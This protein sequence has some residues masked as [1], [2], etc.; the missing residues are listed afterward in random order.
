MK[1]TILKRLA[2][3]LMAAAILASAAVGVSADDGYM[4]DYKYIAYDSY[5]LIYL[6]R[7]PLS[8]FPAANARSLTTTSYRVPYIIVSDLDSSDPTDIV[9]VLKPVVG[10]QTV[11]SYSV[12][13]FSNSNQLS[14]SVASGSFNSSSNV[15]SIYLSGSSSAYASGLAPFL[16]T[17]SSSYTPYSD[18]IS[19]YKVT[20]NYSPGRYYSSGY[21]V[22]GFG[23]TNFVLDSSLTLGDLV[24][25]GDADIIISGIT[26]A[27]DSMTNTLVSVGS[28]YIQFIPTQAASSLDSA[29]SSIE[30]SESALTGKSSSL[31]ESVA[32]EWTANKNTART[33]LA[34]IE[35]T[36][37]EIKNIYTTLTNA[38]PDEVL[39]LFAIIP[40]LLFIGFLIGRVK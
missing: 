15:S 19:S 34:T 2:V 32:S 11:E 25:G 40:L 1:I 10:T 18:L 6:S 33:F 4:A 14:F 20:A 36:A 21:P 23:D 31:M 28:D 27:L 35:P 38:M 29:V 13:F 37:V 7:H 9:Y 17:L 24:S 26:A 22:Y 39:A 3:I 30:S 12:D 5:G 16:I 8:F